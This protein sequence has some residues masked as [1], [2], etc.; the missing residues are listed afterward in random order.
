MKQQDRYIRFDWVVKR[1]LRQKATGLLP[2]EIRRLQI[3][4]ICQQSDNI[5]DCDCRVNGWGPCRI[6]GA[7][8]LYFQRAS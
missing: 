4:V 6:Q 5:R 8:Q 1:L 7:F 2:E 3:V